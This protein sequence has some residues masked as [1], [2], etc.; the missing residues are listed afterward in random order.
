M[1]GLLHRNFLFIVALGANQE[2]PTACKN[3]FDTKHWRAVAAG[4]FS[5]KTWLARNFFSKKPP[6]PSLKDQMV[7]PLIDVSREVLQLNN[8]LKIHANKSVELLLHGGIKGFQGGAIL[9]AI[10]Q[11][12]PKTN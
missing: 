6:P 8:A 4:F 10:F 11:T 1:H 9:N 5:T 12:V 2:C 7:G 3:F